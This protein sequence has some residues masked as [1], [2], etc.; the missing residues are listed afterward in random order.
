VIIFNVVF[1]FLQAKLCRIESTNPIFVNIARKL[2]I[3]TYP[4]LSSG[5]PGVQDLSRKP[6][7]LP[8]NYGNSHLH[9]IGVL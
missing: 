2:G 3:Q 8:Q 4:E 9:I 7:S 1:E 5:C 6:K